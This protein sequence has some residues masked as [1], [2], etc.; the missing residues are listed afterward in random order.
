MEAVTKNN[1]TNKGCLQWRGAALKFFSG[2][3]LIHSLPLN[4]IFSIFQYVGH[5]VV[6]ALGF[7]KAVQLCQA[8]GNFQLFV[9]GHSIP[10]KDKRVLV[11]A[12]RSHSNAPIV[13][14]NRSDEVP[15]L[16]ANFH[17]EPRPE[18]VL[19]DRGVNHL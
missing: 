16:G 3:N 15:V 10:Y 8:P 1:V 7:A 19:K 5:E 11:S 13:A 18:E 2:A 9:L 12:F 14:L 6:S 17:I 4:E